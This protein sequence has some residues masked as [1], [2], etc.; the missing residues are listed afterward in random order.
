MILRTLRGIV[1]RALLGLLAA[2]A[3]G[4]G[5]TSPALAYGK[6]NWQLTFSGTATSPGTGGGFGFWGWCDLAD[7]TASSGGFAIQGNSGDCQF[8][9]YFH[10]VPGVP[11]GTCGVGFDLMPEVDATGHLQPAWQVEPSAFTDLPDWFLSGT[12]VIKPTN[13]TTTCQQFPGVSPTP[14]FSNF[15]SLL[16]F[17]PGHSNLNFSGIFGTHELQ[18]TET[19]LSA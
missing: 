11:S 13:L 7:A 2:A 1:P 16:P 8:A 6:A 12:Q 18:I 3:L 17:L 10:D 4:V 5:S 9:E 19:P 14:T 15:D